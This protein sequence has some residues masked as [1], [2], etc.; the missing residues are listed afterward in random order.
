M[1]RSRFLDLIDERVVVYDGATGTWLQM[2]GLTADDFGGPALEGCNENLVLTR[3]DVIA[4]L[5]DAYFAVGADVVETNSFGSSPFTLAEYDL[6]DQAYEINKRAGEIAR[7]VADGYG[8]RFVAGSIGPGTKFPSLGQIRFAELRDAFEVQARGLLDGG[9]D[10]L[11]IETQFDLLGAKAAM[12]GCRRAMAAT[13]R[14]VPLQV[15]VTV[16]LTG[17]MLPGTEIAAALAALDPLHPDVFGLN[18]ATGPTEM[19]EHLRHLSQ[20]ARMPVSC[21]PNAGLPSVV[22]GKM[23]YDLT[24]EQFVAHHERFITELGVRVVGGCCGT[25][26]EFIA[27]LVSRVGEIEPARRE[28]EHEPGAASIYS[29]TPFDQDITYLTVGERTN[30]NGS[31]KFRDAMLEADWDTCVAMARE[32]EK[33]GAHVLDVCV[34]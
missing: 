25:T 28:P 13:G 12:I 26:P 5:H 20:H 22:D 17:R 33:E 24:A 34:D 18:C 9:V 8:N 6:A 4:A 10:L 2:Q 21:L 7:E 32:Q 3:P 31:R 14:D 23:H 11:L 27:Q 1:P 15:Q 16:E 29:F 19:T 30:A